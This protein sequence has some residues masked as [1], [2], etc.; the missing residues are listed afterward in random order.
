[1][2]ERYI[3]NEVILYDKPIIINLNE[4]I[5]EVE[6]KITD[7]ITIKVKKLKHFENMYD[8]EFDPYSIRTE[9]PYAAKMA[10]YALLM[11]EKRLLSDGYVEMIIDWDE[12]DWKMWD[13]YR[14]FNCGRFKIFRK[15]NFK[16]NIGD[17]LIELEVKRILALFE[18]KFRVYIKGFVI[19]H[20]V[21]E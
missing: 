6:E 8:V 20:P 21:L 3:Q 12:K 15:G 7:G 1:M 14:V 13:P 9:N 10:I 5:E 2:A 4:A 16:M 19:D 17:C 18:K 11:C